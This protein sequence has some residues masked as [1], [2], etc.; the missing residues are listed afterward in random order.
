MATA[1]VHKY[2]TPA[3]AKAVDDVDLLKMIKMVE[4]STSRSHVMKVDELRSLVTGAEDI[5]ELR[6]ENKIVH[7]RLAIYED[8]RAQVEFKIIKSKIIQRLSISA[9]KQA[10]LKL[11]VCEDMACTKHKQLTESPGGAFEGQRVASLIKGL[12]LY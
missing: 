3:W 4:M 6:S 8:A 10:E 7:S 12:R 9:R 2:W 5:D 11:K 1:S